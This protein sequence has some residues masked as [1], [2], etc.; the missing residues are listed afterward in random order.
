MSRPRIPQTIRALSQNPYVGTAGV[1]L[2]AGIATLNGRLISVG[3]PDLRGALG[4]GVDEGSWIPTAYNMAMMFIGP[5]SVFLGGLL[6]VRRVLLWSAAVFIL[7]SLL[8]PLSP[9]LSVLLC[10]Q[11]ISGL[12]SG[13]FYPLTFTYAARALPLRYLV[14]AIGVYPLDIIGATGIAVPLEAW[15]AEHLSW[16]WLFWVSALITLP[17]MLCIYIAVPN[18]PERKGPKPSLS[19]RGF[20]FGCLGL[21]LIFGALDQG[22]RLDWLNSGVIVGLLAAGVF[23]LIVTVIRR[24][25]SPNP[26]VNPIFIATRNTLILGACL[27]SF[28]FAV[29]A[30]AFL[31][32]AMLGAI[33]GY[34]PLETG[35]VMLWLVV[36]L[37]VAGLISVQL[38]RRFDNRLV[39]ASGF[40]VMVAACTLNAG[41]TSAWADI[42]FFVPQIVMGCG[43]ALAFTGLVSLLV[44]NAIASGGLSTPLNLLTYSAYVHTVRL[45]GGETGSAIMQRLVAVREKFHSNMIGLHVTSGNWITDEW[46]KNVTGGLL[47]NSAGTEEA[48]GRAL[49]LLGGQVRKQ[50]YTLAYADGFIA[51]AVV[52]ILA[53]VLAALMSPIKYY[54]DDP[55]LNP[56][57]QS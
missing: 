32:P 17:M 35:R 41:L 12:S 33:H 19:W 11:V 1:F 14:Y 39:L 18:P 7:C 45:F 15:L 13:T 37:I 16:H 24:W 5:F 42:N 54:F 26:L 50:A 27:F 23:L 46:V 25:L 4:F 36:P 55:S 8:L 40:A 51:I 2:G 48:Q 38:L 30:I 52:A 44:Q 43:L 22:E 53:I 34:R 47:P 9:N 31:I 28:R 49:Q 56:P 3:L 57:R 21:A 10:L 6:G 29:L 20:L